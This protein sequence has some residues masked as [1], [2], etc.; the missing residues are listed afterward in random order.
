M[1][2][3]AASYLQE[4]SPIRHFLFPS[5]AQESIAIHVI[6]KIAKADVLARPN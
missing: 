6:D 3:P 5:P 1:K 2:F 4:R